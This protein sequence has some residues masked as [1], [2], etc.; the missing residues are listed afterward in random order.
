MAELKSKLPIT[1]RYASFLQAAD[2]LDVETATPP[3]RIRFIPAAELENEQR[4]LV[5]GDDDNPPMTGWRDGW[6][7]I[8]H[9]AMLGDPYFLDTTRGDAEGDC[10]VYTAMAG[11]DRVEPVLCASS[12]ATFVQILAVAMEVAEGFGSSGDPDD[13]YIFKEA[14]APRLRVIDPTALREGHWTS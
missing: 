4:R 3:E 6:V 14:L 1:N 13:E 8:A 2:P 12:F 7:V 10:P 9:S 5:D 11:T